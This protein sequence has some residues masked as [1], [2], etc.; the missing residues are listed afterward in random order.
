MLQNKSKILS[1]QIDGILKYLTSKIKSIKPLLIFTSLK[2]CPCL[3]FKKIEQPIVD[4]HV[5]NTSITIHIRECE[6]HTY[7][8]RGH[9]VFVMQHENIN[10]PATLES[11]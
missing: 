1:L 5:V 9:R 6:T 2:T 3:I 8:H 7:R 4:S 11:F 10:Y